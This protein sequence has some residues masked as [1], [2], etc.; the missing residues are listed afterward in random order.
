MPKASFSMQEQAQFAEAVALSV[1]ALKRS[2][3]HEAKALVGL[4]SL[5]AVGGISLVGA[6]RVAETLRDL[7]DEI[8]A[9][10]HAK[11]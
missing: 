1:E 7:A 5:A 9:S 8:E 4:L 6:Q 3:M 11:H 10:D 2:G